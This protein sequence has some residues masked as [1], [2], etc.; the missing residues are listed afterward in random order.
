MI[1]SMP[2]GPMLVAVRC[3]ATRWKA[4]PAAGVDADVRGS[5][6]AIGTRA[7]QRCCVHVTGD[8]DDEHL[9]AMSDALQHEQRLLLATPTA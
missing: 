5:S 9:D 4:R 3:R 6:M 7:I 2:D 1:V 8:L